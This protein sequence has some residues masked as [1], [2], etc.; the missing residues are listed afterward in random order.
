[1]DDYEEG[2]FTPDISDGTNTV[3][4][5]SQRYTKIG[6]TVTCTISVFN[7]NTSSLSGPLKI[8]GLPFSTQAVGQ[9]VPLHYRDGVSEGDSVYGYMG[10]AATEMIL[11]INKS[12]AASATNISATAA[13]TIFS[14]FTYM[15]D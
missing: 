10:A 3:T 4:L 9:A 11:R 8:T 13:T 6:R 7:L 15:V 2:T 12:P 14:T 1:M 5:G